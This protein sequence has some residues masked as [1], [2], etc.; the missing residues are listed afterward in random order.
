MSCRKF[1]YKLNA[2]IYGKC[3]INKNIVALCRSLNTIKCFKCNCGSGKKDEN[4]KI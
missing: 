2:Y 3:G 1:K 4:K